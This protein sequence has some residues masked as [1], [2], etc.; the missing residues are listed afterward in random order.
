[1]LER[2]EEKSGMSQ[3]AIIKIHEN[4]LRRSLGKMAPQEN[5]IKNWIN[6]KIICK[7]NECCAMTW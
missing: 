7:C 3:K 2:Q 5:R 6:L 1:M 4:D